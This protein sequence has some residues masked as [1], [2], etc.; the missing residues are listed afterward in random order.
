MSMRHRATASISAALSFPWPV[1]LARACP[2]KPET[3]GSFQLDQT[4]VYMKPTNGSRDPVFT[5]R[6]QNDVNCNESKGTNKNMKLELK[7]GKHK[8][9]KETDSRIVSIG[10][11]HGWMD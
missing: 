3:A 5:D 8:K 10:C 11:S 1:S 6:T 2:G 7:A 9:D 4:G